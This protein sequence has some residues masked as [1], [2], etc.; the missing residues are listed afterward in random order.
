MEA[1][2]PKH[3]KGRGQSAPP[4]LPTAERDPSSTSTDAKDE[5][6]CIHQA[7]TKTTCQQSHNIISRLIVTCVQSLQ[8]IVQDTD[9]VSLPKRNLNALRR[10]VSTLLLWDDGYGARTGALDRKLGQSTHLHR[11][12]LSLLRS[13]CATIQH[14]KQQD[15]FGST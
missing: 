6:Q 14:G 13:L 4:D 3:Q 1:S 10:S 9:A 2:S 5:L 15:P 12:I 7:N 11:T 8:C